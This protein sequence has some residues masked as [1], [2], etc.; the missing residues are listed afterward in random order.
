MLRMHG[1]MRQLDQLPM[2]FSLRCKDNPMF[3]FPEK[4]LLGL[5]PNFYIHI[6][7]SGLYFITI[8]PPISCSQIGRPIV[9]LYKSLT[10]MYMNVEIRTEGRPVS[11][12]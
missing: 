9:G 8:G 5:I 12:L 1:R 7:V 11:F 10:D 4:K 6:S 3:V 2:L